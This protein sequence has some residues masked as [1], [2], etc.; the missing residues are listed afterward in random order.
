MDENAPIYADETV[1]LRLQDFKQV[2]ER[3]YQLTVKKLTFMSESR[4]PEWAS[5]E[6]PDHA[7]FFDVTFQTPEGD[8]GA[9]IEVGV[10]DNVLQVYH[11]ARPRLKVFSD[12]DRRQ[13]K[14][15]IPDVTLDYIG[16]LEQSG[17]MAWQLWKEVFDSLHNIPNKRLSDVRK[18][19]QDVLDA[20]YEEFEKV[21]FLL[22]DGNTPLTA[23]RDE[24]KK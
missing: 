2:I 20:F 5:Q 21:G 16:Q 4:Y 11:P 18:P 13:A 22:P 14:E 10:K 9:E 15:G 19:F 8:K 24:D 7:W 6:A 17:R 23:P 12:Q 1:V 3:H